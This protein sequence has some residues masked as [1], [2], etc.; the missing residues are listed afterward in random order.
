MR[1]EEHPVL[2]RGL[3]RMEGIHLLD[4]FQGIAT[5]APPSRKSCSGASS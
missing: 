4:L 2:A 5:L 1:G 3:K